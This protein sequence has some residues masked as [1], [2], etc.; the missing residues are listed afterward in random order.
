MG[1]ARHRGPLNWEPSAK[2]KPYWIF[3]TGGGGRWNRSSN[4]TVWLTST[5]DG[6]ALRITRFARLA[7]IS[8]GSWT[9]GLAPGSRRTGGVGNSFN[10]P[11]VKRREGV[12]KGR[13]V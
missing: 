3:G 7:V 6:V 5:L 9:V 13:A 4:R 10:V 11:G 12:S 2:L 8:I 1:P